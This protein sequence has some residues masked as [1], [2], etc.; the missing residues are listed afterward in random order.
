M[1][2]YKHQICS[3]LLIIFIGICRYLLKIFYYYGSFKI[4]NLLLYIFLEIIAGIFDSI[5]I[6]YIKALMEYKF[7]SPYKICYT[8][9]LINTI[10]IIIL[11][12]IFSSIKMKTKNWFFSLEYEGYYYLDNIYSII[13][14]YRYKIF[15]IFC[16][17]TYRYIIIIF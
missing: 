8:I 4:K 12:S 16:F 9:G 15:F 2:F 17:I 14:V 1:K 6:I 3:I 10:I 5:V 7:F 11:M 13:K